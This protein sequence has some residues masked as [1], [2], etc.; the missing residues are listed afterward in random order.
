MFWRSLLDS[1][2]VVVD[3]WPGEL[4]CGVAFSG[5]LWLLD[6]CCLSNLCE[7]TRRRSSSLNFQA[8]SC[9]TWNV[10]DVG[11]SCHTVTTR[12]LHAESSSGCRIWTHRCSASDQQS[13]DSSSSDRHSEFHR[14]ER[15]WS[16]EG[17][18]KQRGFSTRNPLAERRIFNRGRRRRRHSSLV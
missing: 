15:S 16:S 5:G 3:S 6:L 18:L 1:F 10:D 7:V 13:R 8:K 12:T 11:A 9:V 14:R 2:C 17:I 4:S